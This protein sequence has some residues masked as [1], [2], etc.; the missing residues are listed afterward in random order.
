[1][2]RIRSAL[3]HPNSLALLMSLLG[4][5]AAWLVAD[6]VFEGMA[7]IEDEMA[8][9]WQAQA[10][11]GGHLKVPSPPGERSFLVPFVVDYQGWR[12]SKYPLG[13][14]V[15]LALGER[16]GLRTLVNPL[17]AGLGIW[18][19]YRL[20][21]RLFS[22][23]VG[24]LAAGLTLISP[25]FLLN[26]GSLLS[27]P[28]G[29][30]FSVA[31]TLAWLDAFHLRPAGDAAGAA[32][33][34]AGRPENQPPGWLPLL[35]AAAALG[36]LGL[37]RPLTAVAIGL[38]FGLPGL[39]WLGRGSQE[40][41]RRLLAAGLLLLVILALHFAWQYAVTGDPFMN[42][43]TLWWSYDRVGFGPGHGR[44]EGGHTLNQAWVNTRYSLW[45][46]AHDLF[47]WGRFSWIFLPFGLIASVG[48]RRRPWNGTAWLVF[49]QI[50][51]LV[52][53]YLAYWIGSSLFG[54]R[55]FYEGLHVLTIGSAA[56]LAWLAGWP[57]RPGMANPAPGR[58]SQPWARLRPLGVTALLGLLVAT[59]TFGYLPAR[60]GG[61]FGLYG[62]QRAYLEPF[63]TPSAQQLAPAL[64]IVHTSEDWIEYGR[65]LELQSPYL[66]T[67]FLFIVARDQDVD[68]S[69][70]EH[71][72][73]RAVYHY[74]ADDPYAFYSS[75]RSPY[76]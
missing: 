56:G 43:Y 34:E 57:V 60:L 67:P 7:H 36:G 49:S 17:L 41:R 62:V 11:A 15:V 45:V 54:P 29:L 22:P 4:I 47:G 24:L 32:R 64:I 30:V 53:I 31:F 70:R 55:Y 58:L 20:G 68:R 72:P 44:I 40:T 73:E 28:L 42:P 75:P 52:V 33:S 12:F 66:D 74:Y 37:C 25:F 18:L 38:P 63:L 5:L 23:L 3:L 13:W 1:M 39:Y 46:G 35:T 65:L 27:H 69:V 51:S 8:Y 10:I 21:R 48:W 59:S 14:P 9:V 2:Q 50:L 19:I 61:M 6:R 26:S 76:E 16:F 71:F